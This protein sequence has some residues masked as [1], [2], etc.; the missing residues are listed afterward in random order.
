MHEI[1]RELLKIYLKI[2]ENGQNA[3][4]VKRKEIRAFPQSLQRSR[5]RPELN[6]TEELSSA[7]WFERVLNSQC[8]KP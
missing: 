2:K 1:L 4:Y 6:Q 3:L 5:S 8:K 7:C